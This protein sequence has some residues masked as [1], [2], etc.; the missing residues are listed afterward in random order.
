MR[1]YHLL[2]A[3]HMWRKMTL[4]KR[5]TSL[6]EMKM[7]LPRNQISH[8]IQQAIV[9]LHDVEKLR[10]GFPNRYPLPYLRTKL[11]RKH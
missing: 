8:Q 9:N 6:R 5:S 1:T 10:H 3:T 11:E 2:V 7:W 4:M